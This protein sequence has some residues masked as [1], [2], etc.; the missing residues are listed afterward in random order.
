MSRKRVT[1]V[2]AIVVAARRAARYFRASQEKLLRSSPLD[3]CSGP[4]NLGVV[5]SVPRKGS[6]LRNSARLG[7]ETGPLGP[8]KSL[9]EIIGYRNPS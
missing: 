4:Q 5:V 8:R 3:L 1:R 6:S 7:E 9:S 2:S